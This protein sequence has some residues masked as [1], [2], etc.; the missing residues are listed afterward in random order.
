M[1]MCAFIIKLLPLKGS[2]HYTKIGEFKLKRA[3]RQIKMGGN[4]VFVKKL[5]RMI[6]SDPA[7]WVAKP[8]RAVADGFLQAAASVRRPFP[9]PHVSLEPPGER[10]ER[11]V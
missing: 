1:S 7:S 2:R 8:R 3:S 6:H 5:F 9:L 4:E 10:N 11:N